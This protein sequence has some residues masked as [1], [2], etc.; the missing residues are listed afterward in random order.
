M[1]NVSS[2]FEFHREE[3][4]RILNFKFQISVGKSTKLAL[5]YCRFEKVYKVTEGIDQSPVK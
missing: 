5:F 4:C 3:S 1:L 2:Y